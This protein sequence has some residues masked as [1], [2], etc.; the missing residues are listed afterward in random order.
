[1]WESNE[2]S[3]NK[4]VLGLQ[5]PQLSSLLTKKLG[6]KS[7]Q[8]TVGKD[9]TTNTHHKKRIKIKLTPFPK[10]TTIH[11]GFPCQEYYTKG[12]DQARG[13][14]KDSTNFTFL[15]FSLSPNK[16]KKAQ[17]TKERVR[18]KNFQPLHLPSG[19]NGKSSRVLSPSSLQCFLSSSKLSNVQVIHF[20]FF[21]LSSS[22]S[23]C[24]QKK[25]FHYHV[26]I[27]KKSTKK[28]TKHSYR[29]GS[30]KFQARVRECFTAFRSHQFFNSDFELWIIGSSSIIKIC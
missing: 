27:M 5:C 8:A 15:F 26:R 2:K 9:H 29:G 21:G 6:F 10:R 1:M 13:V 14:H 4:W 18:E 22:S 25:N 12:I 28:Y 3:L 17:K 19:C 11:F 20:L 24:P 16:E 23:S 30:Y 7:K